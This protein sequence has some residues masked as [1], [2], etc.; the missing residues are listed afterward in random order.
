[1]RLHERFEPE[2]IPY[3]PW[4][5]AYVPDQ[6]ILDKQKNEKI[7]LCPIAQPLWC[8]PTG[9]QKFLRQLIETL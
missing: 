5:D 6:T 4:Y 9:H 1:M 7:C 8:L 2:E 3:G